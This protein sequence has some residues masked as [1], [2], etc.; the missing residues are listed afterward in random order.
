MTPEPTRPVAALSHARTELRLKPM[1]SVSTS[2][3]R[4]GALE[5]PDAW[6]TFAADWMRRRFDGRATDLAEAA[7]PCRD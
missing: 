3:T 4:E 6:F 2:S 7:T 1:A 5:G